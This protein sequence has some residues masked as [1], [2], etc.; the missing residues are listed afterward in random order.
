MTLSNLLWVLQQTQMSATSG[1][2]TEGLTV[3]VFSEE[4]PKDDAVTFRIDSAGSTSLDVLYSDPGAKHPIKFVIPLGTPTS[5]V[6]FGPWHTSN[7]QTKGAK[8]YFCSVDAALKDTTLVG[9]VV[10]GRLA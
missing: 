2:N 4:T 7:T 6:R 1:L 9:T 8:R 3:S 10:V 5:G